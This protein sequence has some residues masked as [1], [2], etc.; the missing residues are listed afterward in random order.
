MS[1]TVRSILSKA[2]VLFRWHIE[3]GVIKGRVRKEEKDKKIAE[4][5]KNRKI[6]KNFQ[7]QIR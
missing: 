2:G 5:E 3:Q 1:S 7:F 4:F 6:I